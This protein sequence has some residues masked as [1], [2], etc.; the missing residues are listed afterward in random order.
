[1]GDDRV[2]VAGCLLAIQEIGQLPARGVLCIEDVFMLEGEP[3][4]FQERIDF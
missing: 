1:M 2:A 4:Q 3:S